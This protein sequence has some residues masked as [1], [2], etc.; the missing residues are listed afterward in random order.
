MSLVQQMVKQ[1]LSSKSVDELAVDAKAILPDIPTH[2][3][4]RLRSVIDAELLKDNRR[5]EMR[6]FNNGQST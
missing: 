1:F 4:Y 6:V 2:H 3:L 5:D